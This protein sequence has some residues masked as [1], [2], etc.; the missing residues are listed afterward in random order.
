MLCVRV[1]VGREGGATNEESRFLVAPHPPHP[2]L[3]L[4]LLDVPVP[5]GILYARKAPEMLDLGLSLNS[6][7][8]KLGV[9]CHAAF[10]WQ[11]LPSVPHCSLSLLS[12]PLLAPSPSVYQYIDFPLSLRRGAKAGEM[13]VVG[14]VTPP[15]LTS[16][17]NSSFNAVFLPLLDHSP[18]VAFQ[19]GAPLSSPLPRYDLVAVA[20]SPGSGSQACSVPCSS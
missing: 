14:P 13:A 9:Y 12:S 11:S 1:V 8:E 17:T 6:S 16:S 7:P 5:H 10:R 15:L 19:R 20:W 18:G 3:L 4:R 2:P